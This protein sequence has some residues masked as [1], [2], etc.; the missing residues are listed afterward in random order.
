MSWSDYPKR[1]HDVA[2]KQERLLSSLDRPFDTTWPAANL[3]VETAYELLG[4]ARCGSS[5]GLRILEPS[6]G[7]GMIVD[8]FCNRLIPQ[9]DYL[10]AID[11]DMRCAAKL[12]HQG[13]ANEVRCG[14][15]LRMEPPLEKDAFDIVVMRPPLAHAHEHLERALSW[16]RRGSVLVALVP[17]GRVNLQALQRPWHTVRTATLFNREIGR[18]WGLAD[19][20]LPA[21]HDLVL[22]ERRD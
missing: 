19:R 15:F 10:L 16:M 11:S 5:R 13:I 18:E 17:E 12:I 8:A 4:D 1:M 3:L 6:C 7:M 21:E 9:E 22:I 20:Q 2:Q 14:D